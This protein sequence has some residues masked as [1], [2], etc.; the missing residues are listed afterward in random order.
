MR[1]QLAKLFR[2]AVQALLIVALVPLLLDVPATPTTPVEQLLATG[3]APRA[4]SIALAGTVSVVAEAGNPTSPALVLIHGFGGSTFGWRAVMAPIAARGWHVIAVDLPGFGLSEKSWALHYDH[5]SQA[6]F[7]LAMM[8]ALHIDRAVIVGHS[9]GGNVAAWVEALAPQRVAALGLI[10]AAII[11]SP[12]TAM[13]PA[14]S[15]ATPPPSVVSVALAAAPLRRLGRIAIR[16]L[17]TGATFGELLRSA[18]V[19][20]AAA[21]PTTIA[22]YAAAS[23]VVDWDLALLGIVRDARANALPRPIAAIATQP[24]L[25]LWGGS[26]PWVSPANGSALHGSLPGATYV[27]L[28]GLGHVPFEEAPDTFIAALAGWLDTL[29]IR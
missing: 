26:D 7:V 23:H 1:R 2:R 14:V 12:T 4:R 20:K 24:T 19:V 11:E 10:D 6:R 5:A 3:A 21:S 25:I 27:V 28:P 8:D 15:S 9:M 22:G 29:A 17:F 18:F 13:S 16:S